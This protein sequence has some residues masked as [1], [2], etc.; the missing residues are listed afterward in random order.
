M[1]LPRL[2]T[3]LKDA[4]ETS[5]G[6][7][8]RRLVWSMWSHTVNGKTPMVNLWRTLTDL[9]HEARTELALLI[10][11]DADTREA[12][13]RELLEDSGEWARIDERPLTFA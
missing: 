8:A 4:W 12:W 13:L 7:A 5:G 2:H 6:E 3:I 1:K 11:L 9:D 10:D